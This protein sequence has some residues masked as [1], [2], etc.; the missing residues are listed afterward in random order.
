LTPLAEEKL[1]TLSSAHLDEL[2]AI[3]PL[4]VSLLNYFD[5]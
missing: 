1:A 4:L 3:R 5:K 2:R